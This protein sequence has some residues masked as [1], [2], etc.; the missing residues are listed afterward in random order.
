[1]EIQNFITKFKKTFVYE[2]LSQT[3]TDEQLF[4]HTIKDGEVIWFKEQ[5]RQMWTFSKARAVPDNSLSRLKNTITAHY[6]RINDV[7]HEEGYDDKS[8][9]QLM[10]LDFVEE[11]IDEMIEAQE[12]AND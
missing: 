4:A 11:A 3:L 7:M 9:G 12:P 6:D 2:V 5:M 8:F 1:M 10:A